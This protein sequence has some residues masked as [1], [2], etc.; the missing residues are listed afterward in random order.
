MPTSSAP[1]V[2]KAAPVL[3]ANGERSRVYLIGGTADLVEAVARV[4]APHGPDRVVDLDATE[5]TVQD[6]FDQIKDLPEPTVVVVL[7]SLR[8]DPDEERPAELILDRN[9]KFPFFALRHFAGGMFRSGGGSVVNVAERPP[10]SHA[11]AAPFAAAAAGLLSL[12]RVLAVEWAGQGVRANSVVM[13]GGNDAHAQLART[14]GFFAGP[15]TSYVTGQCI[16]V[17]SAD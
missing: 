3:E 2:V 12:T 7:P 17:R 11:N 8:F 6:V 1:A 15:D 5:L 16:T 13:E 4:V 14:I 9:L 10:G